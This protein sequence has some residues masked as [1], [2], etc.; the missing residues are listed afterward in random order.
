MPII[1]D[2]W[3]FIRNKNSDISD[4]ASDALESAHALIAYLEAFQNSHN[5]P[6]ILVLDSKHE[7]LGLGHKNSRKLTVVPA[8]D[9]D[10]YIKRY[11]DKTPESQRRNLRVVSSDNS[12][13]YYARSSYATPIKCEEFWDKIYKGA[14]SEA[15]TNEMPPDKI[16]KTDSKKG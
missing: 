12:V 8:K 7:F 3:N 13:Y 4:D 2:G 1:I 15:L 11:I 16:Y 6:I 10:D 5:D 9:A 14:E